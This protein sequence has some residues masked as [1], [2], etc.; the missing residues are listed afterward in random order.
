M[1]LDG[2]YLFALWMVF[3]RISACLLV[4]PLFGAQTPL[5]VR[6]GLCGAISFALTPE[7]L[8]AVG[9][10]PN[11]VGELV[12]SIGN[13]ALVGLVL[14]LAVQ[15]VMIAVQMAGS[16]LDIQIGLS[17]VQVFNPATN[18][19]VSLFANFKY[20]LALVLML[21]MNGHHLMIKSFV[22]S[23]STHIAAATSWSTAGNALLQWLA[24]LGL[25]ALQ[26]CAA[27]VAVCVLVDGAASMINRSV[28][29]MQVYIVGIP[30]KMLMGFVALSLAL[31]LTVTAVQAGLEVSFDYAGKML[32]PV[33]R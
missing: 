11:N 32:A 27:P 1:S 5:Q 30:A 33:R 15:M 6:L 21:L 20:W 14:G 4:A 28:P 19:P 23:Y 17:S 8:S 29:Q 10:T 2:H 18:H 24:T 3:T 16:V 9:P 31:P 13:E 7:L 26:I 12:L 22:A 25:L